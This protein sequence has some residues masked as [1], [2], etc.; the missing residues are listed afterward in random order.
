[1]IGQTADLACTLRDGPYS[2]TCNVGSK[3]YHLWDTLHSSGFNFC[4]FLIFLKSHT[5]V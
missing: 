4:E 2:K 1:V 3:K 5:P